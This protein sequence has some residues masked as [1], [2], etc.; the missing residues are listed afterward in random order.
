MLDTT[1]VK[2]GT[3][4][5]NTA[6]S[7]INDYQERFLKIIYTILSKYFSYH[8]LIL[9]ISLIKEFINN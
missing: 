2:T 3:I 6:L 4:L 7:Q 8:P 1:I 5:R 9:F